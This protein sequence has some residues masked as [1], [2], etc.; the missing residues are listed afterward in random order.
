MEKIEIKKGITYISQIVSWQRGA[1][2]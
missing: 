2:Y 1:V